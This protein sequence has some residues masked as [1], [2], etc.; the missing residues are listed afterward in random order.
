MMWDL[1]RR[2]KH[3]ARLAAAA[4]AALALTTG[5]ARAADQWSAYGHDD[6][7]QRFSPL[8][9]IDRAN[10]T[11]LKVAWVFHTGDIADGRTGPR[12][13]FETTPL[14]VG[15]TLFLTTP[16]NRIIALAPRSGRQLWAYDPKLDRS[17]WYG[18]GLINRGLA[19]WVD[20]SRGVGRACQ[21]RLFEATLDARLVAID[22]RTGQPCADFGANGQVS[23]RD[24][25][26]YRKGAY[27]MTSP[28]AVIDGVVVVGSAIDDNGRT[29]MPSGV[30]RAYDART[31]V[32][33]WGWRP[34][35]PTRGMQSG[36]ANAWSIMATDPARHL[37]FAPTGSASPDYYGGMRPGD[38]QWADSVVALDSRTGKLAW[39]FQLVHHDL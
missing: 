5:A 2:S 20:S 21:R 27:H 1:G 9:Q 15:Q 25:E 36:A 30:V 29:D 7:G 26:G 32:L 3:A 22:A 17:A 8:D 12:S 14:F 16:F 18:D 34:L 31:G 37:V 23:L 19:T 39:G 11:K 4:G 38:N 35:I 6:T 28:P 13:G 24:V 33:R 10:V